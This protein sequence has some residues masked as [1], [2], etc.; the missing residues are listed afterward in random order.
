M[1]LFGIFILMLV[2][3][4]SFSQWQ[5]GAGLNS[6]YIHNSHEDSA[7]SPLLTAFDVYGNRP[8]NE[9]VVFEPHMIF[10]INDYSNIDN[11]TVPV[12]I[13]YKDAISVLTVMLDPQFLYHIDLKTVIKP[14]LFLSPAFVFRIPLISYGEGEKYRSSLFT[15]FNGSGHFLYPGVG[16]GFESEI[17]NKWDIESQF[18]IYYP[19]LISKVDPFDNLTIKCGISFKYNI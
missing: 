9:Y 13:E 18:A 11:R 7:P 10:W 12:E 4:L 15:N 3:T 8:I 1:R 14:Y 6:V 19:L 5:I 17:S 2:S 16:F